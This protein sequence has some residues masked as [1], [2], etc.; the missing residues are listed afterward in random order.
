MLRGIIFR[1]E[2]VAEKRRSQGVEV[3]HNQ[4]IGKCSLLCKQ[5]KTE[6]YGYH[7]FLSLLFLL[8][9]KQKVF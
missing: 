5:L 1:R 9:S 2:M 3:L 4:G 7:L 6:Y 8:L